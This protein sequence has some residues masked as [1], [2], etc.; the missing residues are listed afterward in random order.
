MNKERQ[1]EE[2]A[3]IIRQELEDYWENERVIANALYNAGY[4]QTVNLLK[5]IEKDFFT[6]KT[7]QGGTY[8]IF[9][10]VRQV[11]AKEI[12]QSLYDR[13]YERAKANG[14]KACDVI[15]IDILQ[16]AE[17]YGVEIEE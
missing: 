7:T 12:L 5:S 6:F 2:M 4:R 10:T 16:I 11:T 3:M 1:I 15:P 8:N 14:G 17:K 13:C 9:D